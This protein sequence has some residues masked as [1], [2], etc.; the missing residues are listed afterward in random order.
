M[1]KVPHQLLSL[2]HPSTLYRNTSSISVMTTIDTVQN[3]RTDVHDVWVIIA[4]FLRVPIPAP[5]SRP[6]RSALR[7]HDL[8]VLCRVSK[9][10]LQYL[11]S[12][13]HLR[14]SLS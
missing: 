3:P 7:Q 10:S 9:V 6:S 5:L 14:V 4:E 8:T 11:C 2:N 12:S 13:T 1:I